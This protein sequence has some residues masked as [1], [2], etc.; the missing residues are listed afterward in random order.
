MGI[1][2]I[3]QFSLL[4][5]A[6]GIIFYFWNVSWQMTLFLHI[7]YEWIEN[8]EEG[9][10]IINRLWVWPG[11]KPYADTMTNRISDT[12]FCLIGWWIASLADQFS[13]QHHLYP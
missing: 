13:E 1:Y 12:L 9:M 8:T 3:D 4:H 10:L 7:V 2:W 6:V 5:M 11:G